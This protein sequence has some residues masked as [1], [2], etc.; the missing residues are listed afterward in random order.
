[1]NNF[2]FFKSTDSETYLPP[3]GRHGSMA[4]PNDFR[5]RRHEILFPSLSW[6]VP[7]AFAKSLT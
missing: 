2:Y 3:G 1:M 5:G 6:P 4:A 7:L